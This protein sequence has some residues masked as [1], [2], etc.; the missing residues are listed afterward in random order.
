MPIA[1]RYA[2]GFAAVDAEA[3]A[4]PADYETFVAVFARTYSHADHPGAVVDLYRDFQQVREEY[5]DAGSSKLA[6][7]LDVPRS[8]IR[9][10]ADDDA[11]PYVVQGLQT[12][13]RRGWIPMEFDSETFRAVNR[14]AAWVMSSG[15][16]H[17]EKWRVQFVVDDSDG[18][19]RLK[20]ALDVLGLSTTAPGEAGTGLRGEIVGVTPDG[21]VL[22][23]VLH[24]LG[25]PRGGEKHESDVRL[26]AYLDAAP[27]Q[28]REEW[29]WEY[30]QQRG[31]SKGEGAGVS[32]G[33]QRPEAYQQQLAAL[34]EDLTGSDASVSEEDVYV[35]ADAVQALEVGHRRRQGSDEDPLPLVDAETL[36]A[37]YSE[38]MRDLLDEYRSFEAT[39]GYYTNV[40]RELAI[41]AGR[42]RRW[43][44]GAQPQ[45]VP[46]IERC[47]ERGWF[48]AEWTSVV[49]A[50]ADLA[51]C[52][53]A[54]GSIPDGFTPAWTA[55][56]EVG[57]C[58]RDALDRTG[59]GVKERN[60]QLSPGEDG[61]VLGRTLV[62]AGGVY[63]GWPDSLPDWLFEGSSE[64]QRRWVRL[65]V[66]GRGKAW[67]QRS[68][69][70]NY[71][72]TSAPQSY[73]V[74][75]ARLVEHVTGEE[76]HVREG[77]L[78]ISADAVR[79]L[80]LA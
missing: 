29:V 60:G 67:K 58:V 53:H 36:A 61:A 73:L 79:E 11:K 23:R 63:D 52:V 77:R 16:I 57:S 72:L 69:S 54:G 65:L 39:D 2:D 38:K 70:R 42:A 19:H 37:T 21:A 6:S 26:P 4:D 74:D 28:I 48:D 56:D 22:G 80:G 14:L 43:D 45:I 13:E 55:S 44:E 30:L 24:A 68:P 34:V 32:I 64:Q 47:A 46:V 41:P 1:E 10:W 51:V 17:G 40:A 20:Q 27:R 78:T 12:A 7:E 3:V 33:E 76:V 49:E 62:A 18:R 71:S 50:I 8:T 15:S 25:V 9:R 59:V 5:P 31:R 66:A 35:S 75:V